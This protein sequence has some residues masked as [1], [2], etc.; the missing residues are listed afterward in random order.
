MEHMNRGSEWNIWDL[1]V[2]TPESLVHN[3]KSSPDEAVWEKYIESLEALPKEIKVL[4]IND[5]IFI[6]GYRK[7]L[8]YR[9]KGRLKNR[10]SFGKILWP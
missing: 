2:H 6:D 5:Y 7:V 10:A 3:Y 1:H 8:E 9:Q 4:G